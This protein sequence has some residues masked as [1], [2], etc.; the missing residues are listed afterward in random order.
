MDCNIACSLHPLP[1]APMKSEKGKIYQLRLTPEQRSEVRELTGKEAET[2]EL[3]IEE[4][5][6]RI[7]PVTIAGL[8][9]LRN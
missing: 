6:E 8:R 2:L 1:E 5:E 9:Q 3:S 7:A 4:L